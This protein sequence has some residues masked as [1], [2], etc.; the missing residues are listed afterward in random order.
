[1]Q[2]ARAAPSS[3]QSCRAHRAEQHPS[4]RAHHAGSPRRWR[5]AARLATRAAA[6]IHFES[7]KKSETVLVRLGLRAAETAAANDEDE[8]AGVSDTHVQMMLASVSLFAF[9][10]HKNGKPAHASDAAAGLS[11]QVLEKRTI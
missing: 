5:A 2:R 4:C 7:S 9:G 6:H 10:Y 11:L 3:I 8:Q 1:M